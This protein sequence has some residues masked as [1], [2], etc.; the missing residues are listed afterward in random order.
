LFVR[1]GKFPQLTASVLFARVGRLVGTQMRYYETPQSTTPIG[2]IDLADAVRVQSEASKLEF[3]VDVPSQREFRLK[4]DSIA[5]MN[6]WVDVLRQV[7]PKIQAEM[8]TR[9][10]SISTPPRPESQTFAPQMRDSIDLD[11]EYRKAKQELTQKEATIQQ[12]QSQLV[13]LAANFQSMNERRQQDQLS[14]SQLQAQLSA[15]D[16][17]AAQLKQML[18][19]GDNTVELARQLQVQS[20]QVASLQAAIAKPQGD[21]EQAA[22]ISG[23]IRQSAVSINSLLFSVFPLPELKQQLEL[24]QVQL[25]EQTATSTSKD[26]A[27]S[28]LTKKLQ[29]KEIE[30]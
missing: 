29:A 8:R 23:I 20:E 2:A 7:A 26:A 18:E 16:T 3:V 21:S 11:A 14:I 1:L 9:G 15:K 5:L 4:A 27:L 28:E 17:E 19:R 10:A 25:A 24:L 13:A 6:A 22:V 12:L 30:V